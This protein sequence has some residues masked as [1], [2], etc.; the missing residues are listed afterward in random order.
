MTKAIQIKHIKIGEGIPKIC[1]P[2][3]SSTREALVQ[4]GKAAKEAG[5]ELVEWR[6]DFYEE[7]T[8]VEKTVETLEE[9]S[10]VL[11]ELP[12]LFTLRTEQE[13]GKFSEDET[14]YETINLAVAKSKKA[15]LIDIEALSDRET[16]K[17][18]IR[19]LSREGVKVISSYHDFE[20][21][22][23]REG[24]LRIYESLK[25]SGGDILKVAVKPKEFEDVTRFMQATKEV[26]NRTE[27]P[28]IGIS[29]GNTGSI[30][31]IAGENFGS[32][33]T[34]ATVGAASA[35]GQ[36]RLRELRMMIHSLHEKN[37]E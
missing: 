36:F 2:L 15:D 10:R 21:T 5:A 7:V 24:I 32:S 3:T 33:I 35:P 8:K 9:L 31:R 26:T 11:G 14:T 1:V 34:F 19:K 20:K 18:L 13:G 28:L 17:E 22:E 12:L 23:D 29:M 30:T 6:A 27:K 25:E 37:K 4:E 16:K